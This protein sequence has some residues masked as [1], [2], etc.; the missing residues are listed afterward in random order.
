MRRRKG[1]VQ[2]QVHH[3]HAEVAGARLAHQRIHVGAIH[4][5][6]RALGVQN[7]CDLV[8]LAFKNSNRGGIGQHQRGGIFV[9]LLLPSSAR[10]MHAVGVR[11]EILHLVTADRRGRRIGAVRRVGN[12]NLL[13]RIAL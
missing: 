13:A 11:F 2:V 12:Q 9:H 10:S 7:V 8:N 5:K 4:V 1:L 3:V 6:Q